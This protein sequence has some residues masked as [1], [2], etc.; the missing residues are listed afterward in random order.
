MGMR[1]L[2]LCKMD[3]GGGAADGFLRIHRALCVEGVDSVAYVMK[4]RRDEPA[5]YDAVGMLGPVTRVKW[6]FRRLIAKFSRLSKKPQGVFDF[7]NEGVFPAEAI[8]K[9]ARGLHAS[10]DALIVHWPG[11]YLSPD[12]VAQIA[13]AL[14]AKVGLWQVDMAHMTGGCHYSLDCDRYQTGCGQCPALKSID[15]DDVTR[16]QSRERRKVWEKLEVIV[17][18]QSTWSAR[19]ASVSHVLA[20]LRQVILPIPLNRCA[21]PRSGDRMAAR[22]KLGLP[23]DGRRMALVRTTDPS[24]TYKGFAVL[25]GALDILESEGVR[26]HVIGVGSRGLFS[27]AHRHITYSDL[28]QLNGDQAMETAYH[29]ADFF[30][31]PSIDDAGPMMVP[32]AMAAGRPVVSSPIGIAN[33]LIIDGVNGLLCERPG[34]ALALASAIR[35]Y[36]ELPEPEICAQGLAAAAARDR[37]TPAAFVGRLRQVFL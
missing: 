4:K 10:W 36:A 23:E 14:G 29:A 28:G 34:D 32:E 21:A 9:H 13:Q 3:S 12:S 22:Q 11:G 31:C 2:H 7:D 25:K 17:L 1:V 16:R 33:D 30:I 27:E 15:E 37:L 8:I 19:K 18:A 26:L 20:G 35:K 6:I 5:V 24:I